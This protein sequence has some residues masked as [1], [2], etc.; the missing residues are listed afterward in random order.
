MLTAQWLLANGDDLQ[1][2]VVPGR[3]SRS[4]PITDA[5]SSIAAKWHH[6]AGT[7]EVDVLV[8]RHDG[9]IVIGG[10]ATHSAAGGVWRVDVSHTR[11]GAA[12]HVMS[13]VANFDHGWLPAGRSL[14]AFGEY[15]YNGFGVAT[16][17]QAPL[18]LDTDL[19]D[20]LERGELFS[21]GRHELAGGAEFQ[22]T[23]LLLVS[24]TLI[25]NLGDGSAFALARLRYDWRQNLILY[26]GAQAGL[27]A[28]GTEFGGVRAEGLP[29]VLAP[30]VR[31]W[32]RLAWYF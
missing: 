2:V 16:G 23:P 12:D 30:G 14:Y 25:V 19:F 3:H 29:D 6:F 21:L 32:S 8:A 1:A 15:F 27:G 28:R 9:D 11:T 4:R 24:P 7:T 31:A 18:V 26:A 5:D 13:L 20:R 22:W 10:G 17:S